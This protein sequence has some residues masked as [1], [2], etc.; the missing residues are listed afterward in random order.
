M[1]TQLCTILS[2]SFAYFLAGTFPFGGLSDHRAGQAHNEE[3]TFF[4]QTTCM[5][6]R[7]VPVHKI[8]LRSK[9]SPPAKPGL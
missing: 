5:D 4:N 9:P 6:T 7:E 3:N 2:P 8:S 1:T